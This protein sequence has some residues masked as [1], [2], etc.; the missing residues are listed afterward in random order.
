MLPPAGP[1]VAPASPA[2][3]L[4][5]SASDASPVL[6]K[7]DVI[8]VQ[9]FGTPE[10]SGPLRLDQNGAVNLPLGGTLDLKGLDPLQAAAAIQDRLRTAGIMLD[11][12]VTV[13]VTDSA[14]QGITILGAV[15][16]PGVIPL[17]GPRPLYDV[18]ALAGGTATGA[19]AS[20]SITHPSDPEHPVR[21]PVSLTYLDVLRTT[22]VGPGDIIIVDPAPYYYVL[23]D[24]G[25]PGAFPIESGEKL[26]ILN[27]IAISAGLNQT[28]KDTKATIIRKTP[29]GPVLIPV[30]IK[31]ILHNKQPNIL[32]EASD[33]LVVPRSG[34]KA[35][36]QT[37]LPTVTNSALGI[38]VS[39]AIVR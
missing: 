29:N 16:G 10:L 11:P 27:V 1:M 37:A 34:I 33:V 23:G 31:A 8:Q 24:V 26:D 9:V 13:T 35:L 5:A 28:A 20:I 6:G 32:L 36:V 3:S 7:G 14:R 12:Y 19:G 39:E 22:I 30:N 21:V 17:A 2:F 38:G 15:R 18:L 4:T 25:H